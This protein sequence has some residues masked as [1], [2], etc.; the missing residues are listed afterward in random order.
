L[1]NSVPATVAIETVMFLAGVWIYARASRA[2]DRLGALGLWSFVGVLYA[3]YIGNLLGPPPTS[4]TAL[5]ATA[6]GLWIF[7]VWA[8]RVDAHRS[9][10][11]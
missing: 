7:V 8:G 10:A 11:P 2:R 6:F 4:V 5:T 3:I 1:W 9:P